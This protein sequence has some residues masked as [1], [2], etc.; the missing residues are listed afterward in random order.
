VRVEESYYQGHGWRV[1]AI[2]VETISASMD[3]YAP[4]TLLIRTEMIEI[5]LTDLGVLLLT[6]W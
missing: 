2:K 1:V 6:K 4:L 3:L 5:C